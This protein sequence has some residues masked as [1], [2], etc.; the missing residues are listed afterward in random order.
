[1]SKLF[2]QLGF[3][4]GSLLLLPLI[5]LVAILTM[6]GAQHNPHPA[7]G[8]GANMRLVYLVILGGP[9]VATG[10]VILICSTI[11]WALLRYPRSKKAER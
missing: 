7:G 9:V 3:A 2:I 5:P 11:A 10:T 1:M 8:F 4:L 6:E